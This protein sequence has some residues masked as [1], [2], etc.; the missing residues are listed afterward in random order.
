[1]VQMNIPWLREP[2]NQICWTPLR[3]AGIFPVALLRPSVHAQE[4]QFSAIGWWFLIN[5]SICLPQF[6][7]RKT[8]NSFFPFSGFDDR[9][10]QPTKMQREALACKR[11]SANLLN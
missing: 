4:D 11:N 10:G 9:K 2:L 8:L 7:T 5:G 1:M 6:L 3:I